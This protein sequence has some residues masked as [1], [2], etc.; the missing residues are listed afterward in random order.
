MDKKTFM[1]A[2]IV[3]AFLISLVAGMQV[4]KV[5]M[6]QDYRTLVVPDVFPTIQA[7][8]DNATAGDTV[9][10]KAGTY[11]ETVEIDK[12]LSLIGENSS[13]TIIIGLSLTYG[14]RLLS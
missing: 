4:I 8:I 7:A 6:A 13:K 9:F 12:P 1:A 14:S 3:Y 10:V 5:T 11:N 2:I